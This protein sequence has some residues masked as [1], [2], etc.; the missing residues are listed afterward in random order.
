MHGAD[1]IAVVER[2]F[3]AMAGGV[4]SLPSLI[5]LFAEEAV[6]TEPFSGAPRTHRGRAAIGAC[7]AEAQRQPPPDLSL[8]LDRIAL[9]GEEVVSEWTCRSPVFPA[10]VRGRDRA[11]IHE[12]RIVRL[13][14][15][16]LD[17]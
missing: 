6:Y 1:A 2:Y 17:P 15:V 10:P 5:A 7:L 8:R 14:V 13:E 12:G 11:V 4:G 9:D 16:L 3:E